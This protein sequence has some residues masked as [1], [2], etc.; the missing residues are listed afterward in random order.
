MASHHNPPK[1]SI[2]DAVSNLYHHVKTS[3]EN[4]VEAVTLPEEREAQKLRKEQ[5]EHEAQAAAHGE[6]ADLADEPGSAEAVRHRTEQAAHTLA[7]EAARR[8]AEE[9]EAVVMEH[10]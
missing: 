9:K 10:I 8:K 4:A 6:Y 2:K 1:E 7:A 3:V 5:A